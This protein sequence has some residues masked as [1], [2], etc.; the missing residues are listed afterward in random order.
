M[1]SVS[2]VLIAL[3]LLATFKPADAIF[4]PGYGGGGHR[5]PSSYHHGGGEEDCKTSS[6]APATTTATTPSTTTVKPAPKCPAGWETL[7]RAPTEANGN[8]SP[9][10][11]K[12][13]FSETPILIE[14]GQSRCQAENSNAVMTMMEGEGER[15]FVATQLYNT[16]TSWGRK[17]GAIAVDGVRVK[18]CVSKDRAVLDGPDCGPTKSYVLTN[19]NTNPNFFFNNWAQNEPSANAWT[20]DIEECN[21]FAIDSKNINRTAR[22]NDFYCKMD[23]A[24]NDPTNT[25][26]WNFGVLCGMYQQ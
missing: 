2:S 5:P 16:L 12:I 1:R 22:F 13:L 19:R 15:A 26:Y 23:V 25:V 24:P 10:C 6:S 14:S 21:Q 17:S 3:G 18:N 7:F 8:R 9:Y 11:M 20:Y 4:R